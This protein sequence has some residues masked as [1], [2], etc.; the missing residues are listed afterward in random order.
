MNPRRQRS[1]RRSCRC[2]P[3]PR[4]PPWPAPRTC[5]PSWWIPLRPRPQLPEIQNSLLH[6]LASPHWSSSWAIWPVDPSSPRPGNDSR[7][8]RMRRIG[9]RRMWARR[10]CRAR[11]C[12]P[13]TL[14]EA[15]GEGHCPPAGWPPAREPDCAATGAGT[16]RTWS[17]AA[18]T[19]S[20]PRNPPRWLHYHHFPNRMRCVDPPTI[21][22]ASAA[23]ENSDFDLDSGRDSGC[24]AS[25][26]VKLMMMMTLKWVAAAAEWRSVVPA[27]L[28]DRSYSDDPA[29]GVRHPSSPR[30]PRAEHSMGGNGSR[31]RRAPEDCYRRRIDRWWRKPRIGI[32]RVQRWPDSDCW[33]AVPSADG[34]AVPRHRSPG[35]ASS[36]D[37]I[38]WAR[39]PDPRP[40]PPD[41]RT[42]VLRSCNRRVDYHCYYFDW[43]CCYCCCCCCCYCWDSMWGWMH[44]PCHWRACWQSWCP[45]CLNFNHVSQTEHTTHT[46]WKKGNRHGKKIDVYCVEGLWLVFFIFIIFLFFLGLVRR[47]NWG[48]GWSDLANR[49]ALR[50][51]T[52]CDGPPGVATNLADK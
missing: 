21:S 20:Y 42:C 23:P 27:P 46:G 3:V 15:D 2:R 52:E 5:V 11:C 36:T 18:R 45:G 40:D 29:P 39:N 22:A 8:W 13:P 16:R 14:G 4:W 28:A 30:C 9:R 35:G 10:N 43:W 33:V 17:S 37:S 26:S 32:G 19:G 6:S 7:S 41:R 50:L 38:R 34:T 44:C 47:G 1:R 25:G 31:R 12:S 51:A 24:S 49:L 48:V